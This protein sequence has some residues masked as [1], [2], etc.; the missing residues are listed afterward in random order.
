MGGRQPRLG[1]VQQQA[2]GWRRQCTLAARCTLLLST[3][4]CARGTRVQKPQ[5]QESRG[6]AK[7]KSRFLT[8]AV[9]ISKLLNFQCIV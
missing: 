2:A 9:K 4:P 6:G 7:S 3:R 1:A 8:E 5:L